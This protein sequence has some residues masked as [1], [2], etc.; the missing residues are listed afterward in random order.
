MTE[1]RDLSPTELTTVNNQVYSPDQLSAVRFKAVDAPQNSVFDQDN[2]RVL[3][4]PQTLSPTETS[5]VI[6]RDVDEVKNFFGMEDV[7]GF[8][9][10]GKGIAGFFAAQPQAFAG[11]VKEQAELSSPGY[12]LRADGSKKGS[13]FLGELK[14]SDGGISTEISV[15]VNIDGKEIEIPT[16]VPTLSKSEIDLLLSGESP[17]PEIMNKAV[18]H[19]RERISKGISPFA[20]NSQKFQIPKI[21][22]SLDPIVSS[23]DA[24]RTSI[25]RQFNPEELSDKMD[26]LIARNK[27][28]MAD[29]GLTR[30]EEGGMSGFLYDVG[31]GGSSMLA[32]LGMAA[33]T[34]SPGTAGLYFGAM[35][36]S[37]V[38][39]E[40]R[41][42][43]KTPE[44][45]SDISNV[46]GLVEGALEYVGLDHFM[47]ALKGNSA[48]KRFINGFAIEAIQ[49]SS[50]AAGEEL[51]T[52]SNGIREK[53][54]LQTVQDILYQGALG[55]IIG[56]GSN[57]AIG[58]FV[59][60]KAVEAGIDE[61]TA[62]KMGE[63]AEKN[64][65]GAKD[66]LGEFIDK[67]LAPIARDEK[68]AQEFITL[69]Q[70]FGNDQTLVD[71]DSL[72]PETRKV[73]DQ[74]IEMFNNSK[75]DP[76]GIQE[77]E[78]KFYDQAIAAGID[79][80]QAVA[81][82]KIIGARADAASRALGITPQEW[83]DSKNLTL[84]TE[85]ATPEG[86]TFNQGVKVD[87]PEFKEWFEDS[88][89]VDKEGKPQ[90]V[91]HGSPDARFLK[92]DDAQFKGRNARYGMEPHEDDGAFWFASSKSTANSYADDRRAFDYQNAEAG[93]EAF[94]V[95]L[96]N[97]LIVEANGKMWRDAQQRGKTS[98][99]IDEA[100]EK[101][102]DGVIIKNVR[103]DYNNDYKNNPTDTFVAFKPEQIKSVNNRGTFDANDPRIL[104][105]TVHSLD[106]T[107][108]M[109]DAAQAGFEL[110]QRDNNNARGSITFTNEGAIINLFNSANPSTLFHE[111]GHLFLRDM[112]DVAK[113]TNRPRVRQDYEAVKKWLGATGDT[114][115]RAQEEKFARGFEQYLRDGKAPKPE[116][117]SVFDQFKKWL[118]SIYKSAT[119]LNVEI[120]PEVREA[121]D[122]MLGGDFA[123]SETLNQ[124]KFARDVEKD[125]ETVAKQKPDGTFRQDTAAI[126][127]DLGDRI[128]DA[129][130]PISTRLG[131]INQNLKHVVR[132]FIFDSSIHQNQ[133]ADRLKPF[134]AK[135]D[136]M[137]DEDYR[138]FDLALKNRITTKVD[139][140]V[141]KYKMQEEYKA[142]RELLDE[143]YLAAKDVGLDM[144]YIED[145]FPRRVRRGMA[146]EYIADMRN[147]SMWSDIELAMEQADPDG[148]FTEDD[149]AAF[150]NSYIR[151]YQQSGAAFS[152]LGNTKER[153][154]AYVTPYFNKY[155]DDSMQSLISYV[156]GVRQGIDQRTFFG[157]SEDEMEDNIGK[158][159]LEL[160]KKKE[161]EPHQEQELKVLIKS[162]IS[163]KGPGRFVSWTRDASYAYT[164]GSPISAISQLQDLAYSLYKNGFYRT[165]RALVRA[166]TGN[167]PLTKEDLGIDNVMQ[168]FADKTRSADLVRSTF[169]AIGLSF[170]DNVGKQVYIDGA[171]SRI[172]AANKKGGK[173]WKQYLE[174]IFGEQAADVSEA[175][176]NGEMTDD[177]KYLLFS[178]LSDMQP[179]SIAEMPVGY[180]QGGNW[181]VLY[182]LKTYTVKMWDIYRREAFDLIASGDPKQIATGFGNLT[183]LAICLMLMG[184]STDV[185]KDFLLGR[186]TEPDELV[187]NN[188]FKLFGIT[189][190]Q[191]YKAKEDGPILTAVLGVLPPQ[192]S[193]ANDITKDAMKIAAGKREAKD[194]RTLANVPL[195][196]KFYYWWLGGGKTEQDKKNKPKVSSP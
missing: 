27:K 184:M 159:V 111:L 61:P 146:G 18:D 22:N 49:E 160:V 178:E 14:R 122:R 64:V 17:T 152:K 192:F 87:T 166:V 113:V 98:D 28:Y 85:G 175:L 118:E 11:L 183:R 19:A 165:G 35:Q 186:K 114:F 53:A 50:Q 7:G 130:T 96:Q 172:L 116:L 51:I 81:A 47:K 80:D 99:V 171:Y 105:Q 9:A 135:M 103:D 66:N 162:I 134:I 46:S 52:Q 108:E 41:G 62:K 82:S 150:V 138:V 72:D 149:K 177:V 125:F 37:A 26:G 6:K 83:L 63:Y 170:M 39:Q 71:P 193:I 176:K 70:K 60:D 168:E 13:G 3:G 69:M 104:Y 121:F 24:I 5:F 179:I 1:F 133:D 75:T 44:E 163:P 143:L 33:L 120:S 119:S 136:K 42:A 89:V 157:K 32:S 191:I 86:D 161:I 132:R 21:P 4:L 194:S 88:K 30:P 156:Q 20:E 107:P 29:A 106:I 16:L 54:P 128:G 43:G 185:L 196:G 126:F 48:V 12:G 181:R 124:E 140:L 144:G 131:K 139:F 127:Q 78:K 169:R 173:E 40:A 55:G 167:S 91:Y 102:H 76:V 36:K 65:E 79:E 174:M 15:G 100:R 180:A 115:T 73:F 68:S 153:T 45:A 97:P 59:K 112:R 84:Q 190:Y 58:A 154:V 10:L 2:D 147:Q 110:F 187:M 158:Y 129:F 195:V 164:M 31:S 74:Y 155:Y 189:K 109:R 25:L 117:Q 142:M 182:M 94:Y 137:S 23:L 90:V 141:E 123:Q 67:E 38:Y 8:E 77:V 101:G 34:R 95:S 145:Y 93:V 188:I 92:G 148:K 56:G 151:G 57:V